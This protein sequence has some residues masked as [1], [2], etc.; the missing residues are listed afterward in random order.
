MKARELKTREREYSGL[1]NISNIF[2]RRS[3]RL[4]AVRINRFRVAGVFDRRL[5]RRAV[6]RT[7]ESRREMSQGSEIKPSPP[8]RL[9]DSASRCWLAG[10][11]YR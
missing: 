2:V 4:R 11:R 7:T 6:A 1:E 3:R 8:R 10:A 9:S 5:E